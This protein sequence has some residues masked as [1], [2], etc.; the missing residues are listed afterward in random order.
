M[1]VREKQSRRG[2]AASTLDRAGQRKERGGRR[3][4]EALTGGL[5]LSA[6]HKKKKK[7]KGRPAAAGEVKR[8]GGLLGRKVRR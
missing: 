7:K 3:E 8:A 2:R 4:R 1:G 6:T 5:R